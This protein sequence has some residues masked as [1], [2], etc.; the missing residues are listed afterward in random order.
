MSVRTLLATAA[1]IALPGVA[2]AQNSPTMSSTITL[3]YTSGSLDVA[4]FPGYDVDLTTTSI[5][6][7]SDIMFGSNFNVGLDFGIAMTEIDATGG[8]ADV[9]LLSFALE[10]SYHFGNGAYVGLYYRMGD[11]DVSI[12]LLPITLGV[13]TTQSGIFAGYENGPL[14]I[15]AFYGTSDTDPGIGGIDVTDMGLAMSYDVMPNLEL[16]GSYTR[17]DI[18]TGG[19]LDIDVTLMAIG[20]DYDFGNGL[21]LYGSVGRLDIGTPFPIDL[22]ATQF[23]LGASYD[24]AAAGGG[25]PGVVSLE[26]TRTSFDLA[27]LDADVNSF[28]LALTIPL[29]N[30]ASTT[31]LNSSTQIARGSYRSA[32]AGGLASLR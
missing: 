32:I 28:G 24:L 30:N 23:S 3:G 19:F 4:A 17:T 15:E 16:F 18:D 31:P 13:D 8:T 2:L 10:P 7:D 29:G 25:F 14:W 5:D 1:V 26:M 12:P 9:D 22:D 11:L 20:A 21:A 6:V 27:G